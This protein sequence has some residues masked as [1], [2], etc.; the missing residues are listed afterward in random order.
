MPITKLDKGKGK[1]VEVPT[2][3]TTTKDKGKGRAPIRSATAPTGVTASD[4]SG[5]MFPR[6]LLL[7]DSLLNTQMQLQ[8]VPATSNAMRK[9]YP[10]SSFPIEMGG[11]RHWYPKMEFILALPAIKS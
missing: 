6:S 2:T 3:V 1:E 7:M 5:R 9:A 8:K 4:C 10:L 11:R